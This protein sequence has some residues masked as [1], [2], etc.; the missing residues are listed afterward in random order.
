MDTTHQRNL[1]VWGLLV[2]AF[3]LT[4]YA[5][6]AQSPGAS[7]PAPDTEITVPDGFAATVFA[8]ETGPARHIAIRENGDVFVALREPRAG[9][10]VV[11]LRDTDGDHRADTLERF[12][13]VSGTGI[14]LYK[15]YLYFGTRDSVVRFPMKPE[16]LTPSG[17]PELV[18]QLPEQHT[19]TAKPVDFDGAG[20]LYVNVGG[21]S[22]ACQE[23]SRTP[24]SPGLRPC[25][26]LERHAGI[27]RFDAMK[28]GQQQTSGHRYATGLRNCVAMAW[29][30]EADALYVVMHGRD[31]LNTLFPEHFNDKDNAELPAE[32][33]Y[34]LHD[35]SDCVWPY[36]YWDG[37]K[38]MRVLAPE[39]GGD[40]D[41]APEPGK[42]EAPIQV[43]PAHWAPNDLVFYTGAMF[44]DRY[45]GGAFIAWHGS[46]NRAPLPQRG[47]KVTFTPMKNGGVT[48][49]YEVFA[50]GS[51]GRE[52]VR[53][54]GQAKYRPMGLAVA[55]DGA[56]FVAD[57]QR[58]RIWRIRYE[59]E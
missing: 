31:Q 53:S 4:G 34:R 28:T 18:A 51:A 12:G 2:S 10:G 9:K 7:S 3:S 8:G 56:L 32:A 57:S 46:W 21:P 58:G 55:P 39:Y 6:G 20:H 13:E 29:H 27:W 42:Y 59:G 30:H 23:E 1:L 41:K 26:Q 54:P 49:D 25:P 38:N 44:P 15:G 40:G 22:N 37:R 52:P 43:F 36:T 11:A 19:H 14:A 17:P 50:D 47:F 16:A 24:G 48:D 45:Q 33:F 35:G 5:A